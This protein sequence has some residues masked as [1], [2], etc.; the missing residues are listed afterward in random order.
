MDAGNDQRR[1]EAMRLIDAACD[2]FEESFHSASPIAIE[3]LLSEYPIEFRNEILLEAIRVETELRRKRGETPISTDYA[4]RFPD[5][6]D[7]IE[8]LLS[9]QFGNPLLSSERETIS[10]VLGDSSPDDQQGRHPR[11]EIAIEQTNPPIAHLSVGQS[12]GRYRIEKLLGRGGMGL[13]YL[14]T[15]TRLNR[16]VALKLP[17]IVDDPDLIQRFE[18]EA[19]SMA[20]VSH[21]NLCAIHDVD[22]VSGI[23]FLTMEYIDGETLADRLVNGS[24]YSQI[25]AAKLIQKMAMATEFAH[26]AGVIHRDLKPSNIIIDRENEPVIMDFGLAHHTNEN[27]ARLT[28]AGGFVG[29]PLY[30]APEQTLEDDEQVG[31]W[32]DVYSL[33]AILYELLTGRTVYT[34]K[35]ANIISHL[36]AATPATPP[37]ELRPE[38][39]RTLNDICLRAIAPRRIDRFSSAKQFAVALDQYISDPYADM[40]I[41]ATGRFEAGETTVHHHAQTPQ[42]LAPNS[43]QPKSIIAPAHSTKRNAIFACSVV[44]ATVAVVAIVFL[45]NAGTIDKDRNG[46]ETASNSDDSNNKNPTTGYPSQVVADLPPEPTDSTFGRFLKLQPDAFVSIDSLTIPRDAVH[47]IEAYVVCGADGNGTDRHVVGWPGMSSLFIRSRGTAWAFGLDFERDYQTAISP[48]SI[49]MMERTHLA[50]VRDRNEMRLYVNGVLQ[51]KSPIDSGEL[52]AS[53]RAFSIS[54][55]GRLAPFTGLFDELRVSNIARYSQD[56]DVPQTP[57]ETDANTIG[58]YHCDEGEGN[59]LE[60]ASGNQNHGVVVGAEW[61]DSTA[62]ADYSPPL[63]EPSETQSQPVETVHP[64]LAPRLMSK[65]PEG[66][67]LLF[68]GAQSYVEVPNINRDEPSPF[69]LEMWTKPQIQPTPRAVAVLS[70]QRFMQIGKNGS[71]LFFMEPRTSLSNSRLNPRFVHGE[72]SHIAL[73]ANERECRFFSNGA[74]VNQLTVS[75]QPW[76]KDYPFRGLWLGAHPANG[77]IRYFYSGQLDEIRVSTIERYSES[78]T[79]ATRF[80]PDEH[81]IALYHCDEGDGTIL[82]DASSYGNHGTAHAVVW[83]KHVESTAMNIPSPMVAP[84]DRPEVNRLQ[85]EWSKHLNIPAEES[86][87]IGMSMRLIPPGRFLMGA[88]IYDME[89]QPTE[90]PQHS[91]TITEPFQMSATEVTIEQFREFVNATNYVTQAESD[92]LGAFDNSPK[93]RVPSMVWNT[94]QHAAHDKNLPVTCVSYDDAEA[95]C[96]WLSGRE[97]CAYRLPTEAEWEY[98]CR[99]GTQTTYSFGDTFDAELANATRTNPWTRLPVKSFPANP[100]GLFDMHGNVHEWCLDS[101]RTYTASPEVDP[102][103]TESSTAVVR[104]G[105]GGSSPSRLRASHRYLNDQRKFP[106]IDFANISKGFRVVK[107]IKTPTSIVPS[108][109]ND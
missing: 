74:L 73:V 66:F 83:D 25:E 97:N 98:A 49:V 52:R 40:D 12:L 70:G 46:A 41:H 11:G 34:G 18:R 102:I 61:I 26:R 67:S 9:K 21:R 42:S 51:E 94:K 82:N 69:T 109:Q 88:S 3:D 4:S 37:I 75:D 71:T 53:Q 27:D 60:D 57:F 19:R 80:E 58:L 63:D 89:A 30:M 32:S 87:V 103:G 106:E 108:T 99:A 90:Q 104:G 77:T 105:A 59:V 68:N 101:G 84:I 93:V 85:N 44:A 29:T 47:T 2:R 31:P 45:M 56:F 64:K 50:A 15:D 38:T 35:T 20:S 92:M 36:V 79:P 33:G 5:A 107:E 62:I 86:N 96:R 43:S 81:T 65:I 76:H 10:R 24:P 6:S 7:A 17:R 16:A 95:F 78:F 100:L 23:R 13:V 39:H 28:K 22:E 55:S 8:T 54:T 91:V 1:I 14:A 72:W 48:K